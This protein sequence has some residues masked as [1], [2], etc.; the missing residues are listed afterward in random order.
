LTRTHYDTD[1]I[2]ATSYAD[3][4]QA[5]YRAIE[6]VLERATDVEWVATQQKRKVG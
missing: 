6:E 2:L 4:P 5:L 3:E 1:L